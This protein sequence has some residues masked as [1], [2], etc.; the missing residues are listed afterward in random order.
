MSGFEFVALDG[1]VVVH[2]TDKA[3]ALCKSHDLSGEWTWVPR[4]MCDDGHALGVGDT[5]VSVRESMAD[6]KGLDWR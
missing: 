5:D 6:K 2:T 1:Y 3:V 4:S